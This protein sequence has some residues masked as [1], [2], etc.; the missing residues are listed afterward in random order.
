MHD[1]QFLPNINLFLYP[2]RAMQES[3]L[4]KAVRSSGNFR[5][6]TLYNVGLCLWQLTFDDTALD[7]VVKADCIVPLVDLLKEGACSFNGARA[8]VCCDSKGGV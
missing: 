6:Q 7:A 4:K 8:G 2:N 1:F 3:T 5:S